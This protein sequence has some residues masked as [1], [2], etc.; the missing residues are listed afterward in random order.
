MI[1]TEQGIKLFEM[2]MKYAEDNKK[3]YEKWKEQRN[4]E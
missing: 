4:D 2:A 1:S 3:D